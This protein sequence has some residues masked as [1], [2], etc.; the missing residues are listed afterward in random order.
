MHCPQY[1]NNF[2]LWIDEE[3][4]NEIPFHKTETNIDIQLFYE[5]NLYFFSENERKTFLTA[6]MVIN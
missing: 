5:Y 6:N 1:T 3:Y 2:F 4:F